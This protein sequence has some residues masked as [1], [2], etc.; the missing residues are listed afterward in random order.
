MPNSLLSRLLKHRYFSNNTFLEARVGHSPSL[1]W[2]AIHWGRELLVEGLR[3]KIGNGHTVLAGVDKWLPG[4]N[5]FK[6]ISYSGPPNVHVSCFITEEREWNIPLLNEHFQPIDVDRILSIPLS[7]FPSNDRY[8]WHHTTTGQYT[9]NSGF[10]LAENLA[11]GRDSSGS[12]NHRDWWK[13]LWSLNLPTKIKI[14]AWRVMQNALPVATELSRRKVLTSATC[15]LC[16]NAWESIGHAMFNCTTAR[17]VWRETKFT[18][19]HTNAQSMYHGDYLIHLSTLHSK[20]DFELLVCTMW[21]IWHNR[22]KVTHG[23]VSRTS[24][25]IAMFAQSHLEK[26]SRLRTKNQQTTTC[27]SHYSAAPNVQS[28]CDTTRAIPWTP[29]PLSGLKLNVDAAANQELKIL[30]IGAIIRDHHGNVVAAMSKN[31]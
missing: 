26:Y 8:I 16:S 27:S 1:T 23:G 14:F 20:E 2:Q 29:L 22:N 4:H 5:N 13:T 21:A 30:G 19:D 15:S 18:I 10:H 9:V 31:V 7:F 6:P 17:K 11:E 3:Y 24:S 25:N 28:T 12:N